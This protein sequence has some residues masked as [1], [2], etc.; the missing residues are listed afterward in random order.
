MRNWTW[1]VPCWVW[2]YFFAQLPRERALVDGRTR[3]L[4]RLDEEFALVYDPQGPAMLPKSAAQVNENAPAAE[5]AR[6]F[7][8]SKN[9]ALYPG[10]S[11]ESKF[12][13]TWGLR[14]DF[15]VGTQCD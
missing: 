15:G 10:R 2:K 8:P 9:R 5:P 14:E 3:F 1:L 6:V 13:R 7:A 12:V 4:I 11:G